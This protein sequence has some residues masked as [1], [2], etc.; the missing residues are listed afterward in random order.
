MF[1]IA[2][3]YAEYNRLYGAKNSWGVSAY[4][5][6]WIGIFSRLNDKMTTA[7]EGVFDADIPEAI[8]KIVRG[9]SLITAW[10][11]ALRIPT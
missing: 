11:S 3:G 2:I 9:K 5:I 4:F 7:S 10:K 1:N 6:Q 8:K